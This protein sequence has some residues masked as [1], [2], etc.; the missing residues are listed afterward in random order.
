MVMSWH[1]LHINEH[2]LHTG[3]KSRRTVAS[4]M[5]NPSVP[6][7][8]LMIGNRQMMLYLLIGPSGFLQLSEPT[9]SPD[10]PT[11]SGSIGWIRLSDG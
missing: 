7:Q 8:T 1:H 3:G 6:R 10:R 11:Q 5:R 2:G 4:Y 9:G